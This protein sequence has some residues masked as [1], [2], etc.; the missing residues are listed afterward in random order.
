MIR[1]PSIQFFAYCW[2]LLSLNACS[3]FDP[4]QASAQDIAAA[5]SI[6]PASADNGPTWQ[7]P[8]LVASRYR[9]LFYGYDSVAYRLSAAQNQ[10]AGQTEPYRIL[11]DINYGAKQPRNYQISPAPPINHTRQETV[12]CGVYNNFVSACLYRDRGYIELT[13]AELQAAASTGLN[14]QLQAS[15]TQDLSM[16]LPASYISG[17]LQAVNKH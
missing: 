14:L 15:D 3:S 4:K 12:R 6:E 13:A 9:A 5:T 8:E 11:L 1:S 16:E 7:A 17:F 2:F 10:T